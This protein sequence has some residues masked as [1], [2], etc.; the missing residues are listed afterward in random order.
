MENKS[1]DGLKTVPDVE[2]LSTPLDEVN[3]EEAGNDLT[4]TVLVKL[5]S[6]KPIRKVALVEVFEKVWKLKQA[7]EFYKVE[8]ISFW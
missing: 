2:E 5:A 3:W 8:K 7:A 1:Q 6:G 4:W